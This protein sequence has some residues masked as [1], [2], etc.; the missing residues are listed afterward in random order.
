M[1]AID[2]IGQLIVTE[3]KSPAPEHEYSTGDTRIGE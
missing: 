3:Q 2:R 1:I